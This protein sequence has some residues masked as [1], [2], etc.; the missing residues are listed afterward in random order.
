MPFTFCHPAIILPL[1]KISPKYI[2]MTGLV[3]GSMLPDFE[4]FM[5]LQLTSSHSHTFAGI[6]YFDLPLGIILCLLFHNIV[7]NT[8][9]DS[10]PGFLYNRLSF[11]KQINWNRYFSRHYIIVAVSILLGTASHIFWD[12]FTHPTGF[13]VERITL[14]SYIINFDG[15][16]I[17]VY[18]LCQ[19]GGTV[20]GGF[21]ILLYIMAMP[22]QAEK[23]NMNV[24]YWT[25]YFTIATTLIILRLLFFF[26]DEPGNL[27]A[28][29]IAAGLVS[30]IF[31]SVICEYHKSRLKVYKHD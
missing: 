20:A 19:H 26:T 8:L 29:G 1:K 18:K 3:I 2:S 10:L 27:I 9:I 25:T 4:Y 28:T 30:F 6:F 21:I 7:K 12:A 16:M 15:V 24:R 17:P 5:R 23:H 13:F 22:A 31:T 11:M 14:L